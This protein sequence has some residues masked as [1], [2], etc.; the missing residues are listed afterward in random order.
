MR[1]NAKSRIFSRFDG[2]KQ[3]IAALLVFGLVAIIVMFVVIQNDRQSTYISSMDFISDPQVGDIY[4]TRCNNGKYS[5]ITIAAVNEDSLYIEDIGV[6][7]YECWIGSL[8]DPNH[9]ADR[10]K[11]LSSGTM[12]SIQEV[13]RFYDA[14]HITKI[15]RQKQSHTNPDL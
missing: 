7:A 6:W 1:Q 9:V 2:P 5:T 13:K 11:I 3:I 12:V 10:E 15:S 4:E 8:G 14:C